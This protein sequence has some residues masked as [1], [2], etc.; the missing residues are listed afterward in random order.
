MVVRHG[1]GTV[2][3]SWTASSGGGGGRRWTCRYRDLVSD[4]GSSFTVD[5]ESTPVLEEG[6]HYALLCTDED[7]QVA[8]QDLVAWDPADPLAGVAAE[9]RAAEAALAA[10]DVPAP[11]IAT[12]PA[13][14]AEHL[15]G[16]PTWLWLT[17]WA[18]TSATAALGGVSAT[19]AV[20]PTAVRWD[21]GDGAT[22][23][24]TGPGAPWR[25]GA[26]SDCTH[27]W[28]RRSAAEPGGAFVLTATV[29]WT[30]S[31]TATTGASG[32]LGPLT[33]TAAVPVR[34][35]EAQAVVRR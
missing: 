33:S 5:Y 8:Y 22:V 10:L 23:T 14:G 11:T 7:G 25:P 12:S 4:G 13:P 30:A 24:C 28:T 26:T 2:L 18:P 1:E 29:E 34:V 3:A 17:T 19:V 6:R 16:L 32:D 20:T 15:V 31:W 21:T 27:T 35:V 9:E